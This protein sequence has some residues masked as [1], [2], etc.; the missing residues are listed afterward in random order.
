M[1]VRKQVME[2]AMRI[3]S[4]M[5]LLV[6]FCLFFNQQV[7]P[8]ELKFNPRE[9]LTVLPKDAIRAIEQPRF[10]TP[11]EAEGQMKDEEPVIGI[12]AGVEAKVYPIYLL[13]AHEIVN[14]F[15]DGRPIAITW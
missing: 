3:N 4:L 8:Q 14:D 2:Q 11:L 15:I 1:S 5:G 9:I 10:I 12:E 13:S 7:W 6:T